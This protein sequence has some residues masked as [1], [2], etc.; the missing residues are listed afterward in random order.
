MSLKTAYSQGLVVG[1]ASNFWQNITDI[2]VARFERISWIVDRRLNKWLNCRTSP[3]DRTVVADHSRI[4]QYMRPNS[5][6]HHIQKVFQEPRHRSALK[7]VPP[8]IPF[9]S[10]ISKAVQKATLTEFPRALRI[11]AVLECREG[12]NPCFLPHSN[13]RFESLAISNCVRDAAANI[14]G[15][16]R[17]RREIAIRFMRSD[18]RGQR[19]GFSKLQC[20]FRYSPNAKFPEVSQ[21]HICRQ[22]VQ[23]RNFREL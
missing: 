4:N 12:V 10:W 18:H 11:R 21:L 14:S 2:F 17:S 13:F 6:C 3:N 19:R 20:A 9:H 15:T 7:C 22:R 23:T 8:R 1:G 5:S 16:E